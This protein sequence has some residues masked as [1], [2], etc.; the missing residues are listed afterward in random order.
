MYFPQM[1]TQRLWLV[2]INHNH[3]NFIL[4][5]FS[6]EKVTQYLYDEEDLTN[7]S[8]AV[9]LVDWFS[10]P[11]QKRYNRWVIESKES[12]RFPMGTCGFHQWD[13]HNH[14]AEVGYDLYPDYWGKGYMKEALTAVIHSG[15][16][17][18]HLN[19]IHAYVAVKN[20]RSA[21]LL[22]RLGFQCEG[23]Y[24]DKHHY[25]GEFYDHYIYSLLRRE[26]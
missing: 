19:R 20:T 4:K 13:Q 24:R 9:A 22:E 2:N 26:W 21:G 14:I 17:N 10:Q 8:Q 25:R 12:G 7:Y 11:E 16:E 15:F 6:D 1:E 3:T 23:V 18:M 5:H